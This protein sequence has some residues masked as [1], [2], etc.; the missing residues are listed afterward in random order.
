M[1][2]NSTTTADAAILEAW[3]RRKAAYAIYETLP[4][5][6]GQGAYSAAE[7]AQWAIIDAAELV[8]QTTTATTVGGAEV[9]LWCAV[10]HSLTG[11]PESDACLRADL[12]WFDA[13]AEELDWNVKMMLAAIRSLREQGK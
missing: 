10:Y 11:R 9:Q 4:P 5:H 1:D 12:D 7:A 3:D 13:N 6:E 8:I 2:Q